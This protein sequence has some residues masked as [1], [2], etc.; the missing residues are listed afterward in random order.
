MINAAGVD[1]HAPGVLTAGKAC[2]GVTDGVISV[3]DV[4]RAINGPH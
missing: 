2:V 1:L 4:E 3:A